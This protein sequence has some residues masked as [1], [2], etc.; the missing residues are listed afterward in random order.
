MKLSFGDKV[1]I[2]ELR[3]QGQSFKQLSKRFG[4][5]ASGLK[6]MVK[7]I[8]HYG[9][10]IVKKERTNFILSRSSFSST[11]YSWQRAFLFVWMSKRENNICSLLMFV[12]LSLLQLTLNQVLVYD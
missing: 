2:Y 8:D 9:I 6:Y 11:H 4:V 1:Q 7:L 12:I 10:E 5:D 3:K